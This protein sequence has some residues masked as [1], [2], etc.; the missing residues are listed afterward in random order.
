MELGRYWWWFLLFELLQAIYL[1]SKPDGTMKLY[2]FVVIF[3]CLMLVLAQVPSFHS[4]RHINMVSL[5][6][7]L[8]YSA[9]ATAGSIYI[10]KY[11]R[12][13]LERFLGFWVDRILQQQADMN[14]PLCLKGIHPRG[15][16]RTTP[17]L[18][19]L[20]AV[21]SGCS[22]PSPSLPLRTEMGSFPRSRSRN[23]TD[24]GQL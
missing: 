9:C 13:K 2:E 18:A 21:S 10:G 14:K 20:R 4:L 6:L 19:I 5:V 3:G 7:C 11:T 8:C 16:R 23:R 12:S 15:P 22:M 24:S 17:S 1:L